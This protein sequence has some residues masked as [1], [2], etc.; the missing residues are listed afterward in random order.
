MIKL[1]IEGMSCGHCVQAVQQAL[2][3]AQGVE[4]VVE[5]NLESGEATIVG[6]P[7]I[8]TLIAAVEEEGYRAELME[9]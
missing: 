4:R 7:E 9:A 6:E 1:R 8:S 3:G 5:V 2:A